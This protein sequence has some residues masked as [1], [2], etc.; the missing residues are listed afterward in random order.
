MKKL[1]WIYTKIMKK[2]GDIIYGNV[3]GVLN[4]KMM[5]ILLILLHVNLQKC[6]QI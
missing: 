3:L 4:M 6:I 1:R 5:L 2:E